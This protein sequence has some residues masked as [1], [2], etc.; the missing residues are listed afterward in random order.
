[1]STLAV[2]D[3]IPL[4]TRTLFTVVLVLLSIWVGV[5]VGHAQRQRD[6]GENASVIGP[7]VGATLGL[8]A[9][10][11][12]FT[13]SL[14]ANRYDTRKSYALD[15]ANAIGTLYLRA[16]LLPVPHDEQVRTILREYVDLRIA[17]A[18]DKLPVAEGIARSGQLQNHLWAM[19]RPLSV[20]EP[21]STML[22]LYISALNDMFDLQTKRVTV[23]LQY[24]IPAVIW[25][26]LYLV[27]ALSMAAMGYSFGLGAD[28]VDW[29]V[30]L[31][32]TLTFTTVVYLIADLDDPISGAIRS[33]SAQPMVDL[34][35]QM[36]PGT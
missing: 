3:H 18:A 11:L 13:F 2:F 21:Q 19:V 25:L 32:I 4:W 6:N 14:A 20:T 9:F 5:R 15:E 22:P 33:V 31:I 26:A 23:G 8:L 12:A 36:K 17:V 10:L 28:K 7:A 29:P 1:M 16:S 34:Q 24:R 30:I 35:Q 27:S